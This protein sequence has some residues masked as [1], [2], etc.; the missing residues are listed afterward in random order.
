ML[1]CSAKPPPGYFGGFQLDGAVWRAEPYDE[2]TEL[3][4]NQGNVGPGRGVNAH[5]RLPAPGDHLWSAATS[6]TMPAGMWGMARVYP[7]PAG[8]GDAGFVPSPRLDVDD[9]Y[10]AGNGPLLPLERTGVSVHVFADLDG[11]GTQDEGEGGTAGVQVRLLS[12]AGAEIGVA[13][14]RADGSVTFS[15]TRGV[16]D[17]EVVGPDGSAVVGLATRRVDLRAYAARAELRVGVTSRSLVSAV[18]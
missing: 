15:P 8:A 1:N 13:T 2:E 14:T 17:I 11:D 3:I 16:Y 18:V 4:G 12:T 10:A 7:E 9:P 5:I 6:L